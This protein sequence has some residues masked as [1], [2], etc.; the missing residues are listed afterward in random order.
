MQAGSPADRLHFLLAPDAAAARRLRRA[1]AERGAVGGVVVGTWPELLRQ[2]CDSRLLAVEEAGETAL[3][4]A[5]SAFPSAFWARSL[6]VAPLDCTAVIAQALTRVLA[7]TEP[8]VTL[9]PA[10]LDGLPQRARERLQALIQLGEGLGGRLP[11]ELAPMRALLQA[12][13]ADALRPM[14]VHHRQG[15]PVLDRWQ[16][17]LV[18]KLNAEAGPGERD[19]PLDALLAELLEAAPAAASGSALGHLQR[20]LFGSGAKRVPLDPSLQWVGTRDALEDVEVALG[21]A[22]RLLERDPGLQPADIGLLLPEGA[23]HRAALV[24]LSGRTGLALS[25]LPPEPGLRDPAHELLTHFLRCRQG[26]APAMALAVCLSSPLMPWTAAEGAARAQRLMDGD[27]RLSARPEDTGAARAMLGLLAGSDHSPASLAR[28]LQDFAALLAAPEEPGAQAAL[29]RAQEAVAA[30]VAELAHAPGL[31]WPR[32]LHRLDLAPSAP[33]QP[34]EFNREGLT[35]WR[36]A[37]EPWRAVRHLLVLGFQQGHYPQPPPADPVFSPG[38]TQ[39]IARHAGLA[40]PDPAQLLERA[41]RRFQRQLCTVSDSV[42]FL[43]PRFDAGGRRQGPSE[44]LVFMHSLLERGEEPPA[45]LIADLDTEAGR[46][47]VSDLALAPVRSA[48]APRPPQASE[49]TFAL[50]LLEVAPAPGKRPGSQSPS[51]L[52]TL[53]VSRLGWLLDRLDVLPRLWVPEQVGP[54]LL[55]QLAHAVF[56]TLFA[57]G[58]PLPAAAELAPEVERLVDE[59]IGRLAPFLSLPA[60]RVE[61][62]HFTA[63]TLRAASAWGDVLRQLQAESLAPELRLHGSWNGFAL[64]GQCDVLLALPDGR[65]LVVD[66]KRSRAGGR[67]KR[68]EK[69]FDSQAAFYRIM[70]RD[71]GPEQDPDRRL[72]ARLRQAGSIGIVYYMLTDRVCLSDEASRPAAALPG[73]Q[74]VPGELSARALEL[75]DWRLRQLAEGRLALNREGDARFFDQQAAVPPYALQMSPLIPLYTLPGEA[76]ET[77]WLWQAGL[78]PGQP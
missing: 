18:H 51:A 48:E 77:Q 78:E 17:A 68:M 15:L 29:Q 53:M 73:W 61:R 65:L 42:R 35:V 76:E 69:G 13:A 44:S 39:A 55:G 32:L 67:R 36:A 19:G 74:S 33:Q 7:A 5:L 27:Y 63:Q 37:Q 56:E 70:L 50:N 2:A 10:V 38:E 40:L 11:G 4:Q 3:E 9:P 71:G 30:L 25:G 6:A 28:A 31:D 62:R 26:T 47:A 46:R 64:H 59:A 72:Q 58:R 52:E 1:V 54:L 16:S 41:R 45:S 60:W 23:G 49:L 14:R 24:Q 20:A 43:V 8:G 22:Q 12:P 75:I 34:A 66:Y 21:M 57:P